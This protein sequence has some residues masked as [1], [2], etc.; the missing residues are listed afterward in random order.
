MPPKPQKGKAPTAQ[1]DGASSVQTSRTNQRNE[2]MNSNPE[3]SK[4]EPINLAGQLVPVAF[5]GQT[6]VLADHNGQPYVVMR[7]LVTAMGL[8]WQ[9]QHAKLLEKFGVT[10]TEIVTVADDGKP[11]SMTCL[12]LRKLPGWLYSL[13][14]GKLSADLRPKVLRYQDECDEVLWQHWSRTYVP[15]HSLASVPLSRLHLSY[16]RELTRVCLELGKVTELGLAD[17]LYEQY[18]RLCGHLGGRAIPL[19]LLTPGLAQKRLGLEGG[20]K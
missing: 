10:V 18:V 14:P 16:E 13:N 19:A 9:P 20:A 6:L 4:S 17:A 12:P 7:A 2:P 8:A 11:R 3:G 15:Q 1:T 5:Q